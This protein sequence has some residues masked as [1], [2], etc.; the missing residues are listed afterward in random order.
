MPR[1]RVAQSA[2]NLAHSV[3]SRSISRD[4]VWPRRR[5]TSQATRMASKAP[6][7]AI[8]TRLSIWAP[9]EWISWGR[10]ITASKA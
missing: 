1:R 9:F 4:G 8:M 7:I 2:C 5:I 3:R 6:P 10:T